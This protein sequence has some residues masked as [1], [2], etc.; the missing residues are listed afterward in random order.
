[1]AV[2]NCLALVDRAKVKAN[3]FDE[4]GYGSPFQMVT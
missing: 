4:M 2:G 3:T 1:M